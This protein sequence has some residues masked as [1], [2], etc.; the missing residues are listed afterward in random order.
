[1]RIRAH[2]DDIEQ[3]SLHSSDICHDFPTILFVLDFQ[4]QIDLALSLYFES[5]PEI[6]RCGI[7]PSL[8]VPSSFENTFDE[9]GKI[10]L[11]EISSL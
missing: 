5:R 6:S 4:N 10:D 7:K 2:S 1:M 3:D 8:P 11:S 9:S